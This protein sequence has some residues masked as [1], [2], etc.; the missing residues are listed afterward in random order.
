[1][2]K[3]QTQALLKKWNKVINLAGAKQI[4]E[5]KKRTVALMLENQMSAG[6]DSG[7]ELGKLNESMAFGNHV[8]VSDVNTYDSVLIPLLRRI[9][10]DL[11]ALDILGTQP[12][13]KP[14][15]LI[16][17]MRSYYA[18]NESGGNDFPLP[19][20]TANHRLPYD[21]HPNSMSDASQYYEMVTVI[22]V[23][24]VL[25]AL[26]YNTGD[27]VANDWSTGAPTKYALVLDSTQDP[28][29]GAL[30]MLLERLDSAKKSHR[31]ATY[32]G[33]P[34]AFLTKGD[35]IVPDGASLGWT[36]TPVVKFDLPDEG[37][38]NAVLDN[39]SGTYATVDSEQMGKEI[40]QMNFGIDK[41]T[42]TAKTRILKARYSFEVQEDL[43]AFHGLDAE[44]ELV[45]ILSYEI[46][47]EMNREIVNKVR[48]SAI[49]GG[50]SPYEYK[51][52]DGRFSQERFR[53]LYN[54]INKVANEI[55]ISTRR[56]NGN[57]IIC[58]MDVKVG[59]ES[60]DG[61]EL[62][63]DVNTDFNTNGAIAYA[64]TIGGRYKV[65]VDT[66]ASKDYALVGYKGASEMDAG[67]FYC[68]YVPL[69]MVRAVGQD[70]FQ[71]RLGFRTR[72]G[73]GDNPFGPKLY[74]R[75]IDV[76]GL[77]YAYGEGPIGVMMEAI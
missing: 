6:S 50:V 26:Y 30:T 75:Y 12:M 11:I 31:Q 8:S 20:T 73:L 33:T 56:G 60:M 51:S 25:P 59:L 23:G 28:A 65:Y 61:Y 42:V 46:L 34:T 49:Q 69:N 40:N 48:L 1:M 53:T 15:Q 7:T 19:E 39:Y 3:R 70:D 57:F 77:S 58:S 76:S 27:V 9:A 13:E 47:A 44:N 63:T 66:F 68:P 55:A 36:N 29:T 43:K 16:F 54:L 62:W 24:D 5:S 41:V 10:P 71:P 45:N 22:N 35:I 74:Y 52:V 2:D 64:G 37:L 18:G 38:Y 32:S 67:I 72:Y 21:Q 4:N 14:V 17:A